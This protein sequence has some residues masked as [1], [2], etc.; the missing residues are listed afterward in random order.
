MKKELI[1]YMKNHFSY[2]YNYNM[3]E[4]TFTVNDLTIRAL[5]IEPFIKK[6]FNSTWELFANSIIIICPYHDTDL[7]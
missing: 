4:Y 1:K 7:H 3:M 2:T 5:R 6:Y